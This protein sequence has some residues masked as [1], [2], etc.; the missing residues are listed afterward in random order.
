MVDGGNRLLY[1]ILR[2]GLIASKASEA[3]RVPN[4]IHTTKK[5]SMTNWIFASST[6]PT[7]VRNSYEST[8]AYNSR[9]F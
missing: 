5:T 2:Y 8:G 7:Q 6:S 3:L 9:F 1:L 4:C